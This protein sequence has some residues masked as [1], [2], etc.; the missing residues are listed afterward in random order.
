[1]SRFHLH[2]NIVRN[3]HF[4]VFILD[5]KKYLGHTLGK[6]SHHNIVGLPVKF[7]SLKIFD[8]TAI[9]GLSFHADENLLFVRVQ[10]SKAVIKLVS[11]AH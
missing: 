4:P 2:F 5:S 6:F 8:W 11:V 10:L 9:G 1:M 7:L 3:G